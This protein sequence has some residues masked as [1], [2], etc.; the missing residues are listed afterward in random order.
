VIFLGG[1]ADHSPTSSVRANDG[2]AIP[3]LTHVPAWHS[4]YLI[5]ETMGQ[6]IILIFIIKK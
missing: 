6:L 5:N 2:A 4:A 1:E 3:S